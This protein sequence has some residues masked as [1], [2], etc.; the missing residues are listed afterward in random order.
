MKTL[1]L[2]GTPLDWAVAKCENALPS[3]YNDWGQIWP[4]YSR[5]Y[6]HGGDII[7]REKISV[8]WDESTVYGQPVPRWLAERRG[9]GYAVEGE[10][11]LIAAMRCYV[12]SKLG[13]E[14]DIPEELK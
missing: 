8:H 7:E 3:S 11:Y 6:G 13:E 4:Y 12:A 1:D 14:V 10:T 2:T 9:L 5:I